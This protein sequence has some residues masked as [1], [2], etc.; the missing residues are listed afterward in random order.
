MRLKNFDSVFSG[1]TAQD[2]PEPRPAD[3]ERDLSV[4]APAPSGLQMLV[5]DCPTPPKMSDA[6]FKQKYPNLDATISLTF[7]VGISVTCYVV[8]NKAFVTSPTKVMLPGV[9]S[10]ENAKPIFMYAV[11]SWISESA[12]ASRK[13]TISFG[14]LSYF[15]CGDILECDCLTLSSLLMVTKFDTLGSRLPQQGGQREQD[16]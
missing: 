3:A 11:G 13:K 14:S 12:K 15:V 10:G 2:R 5:E 1:S 16:C 7:G 6:D 4:E 9:L 8:G